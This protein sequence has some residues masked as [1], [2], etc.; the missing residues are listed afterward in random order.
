MNLEEIKTTEGK[1]NFKNLNST[2]INT[3]CETKFHSLTW[4]QVRS[5]GL[6]LA[7]EMLKDICKSLVVI[8]TVQE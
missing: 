3:S 7:H 5:C 2:I 1:Q 6:I 8:C 4:R